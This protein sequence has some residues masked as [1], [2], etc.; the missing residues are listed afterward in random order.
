MICKVIRCPSTGINTLQIFSI[1]KKEIRFIVRKVWSQLPSK[2]DQDTS[3]KGQMHLGMFNLNHHTTLIS[4]VSWIILYEGFFFLSPSSTLTCCPA[5]TH[6][7]TLRHSQTLPVAAQSQ[8]GPKQP[9][10]ARQ[11]PLC[12]GEFSH[13]PCFMSKEKPLTLTYFSY[14]ALKSCFI[15][16]EENFSGCFPCTNCLNKAPCCCGETSKYKGAVQIQSWKQTYCLWQITSR[17]HP[18]S[19]WNAIPRVKGNSQ[20]TLQCL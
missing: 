19:T 6:T 13:P 3:K 20:K 9:A 8:E 14:I 16:A 5:H 18:A 2:Q 7:S 1:Y 10:D 12:L 17:Q 4:L 11:K 15:R